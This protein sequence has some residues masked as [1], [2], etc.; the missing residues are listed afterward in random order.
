MRS[1]IAV[2][3]DPVSHH[4]LKDELFNPS[5]PNNI[6]G[7]HDAYFLL[8]ETFEAAGI[9]SH[10]ADSLMHQ[11][12]LASQNVYFSFGILDNYKRLASRQ[13][14]VLS[15]LFTFEAPTVQPS[16]YRHLADASRHF[17]RIFSYTTPDALAR[18]GCAGLS[19]RP[20]NIPYPFSHVLD[21]LWA[22]E[23]RRFLTMLN[24]NRLSR[25]TWQELYTERLR[26]LEFFSRY[27]EIDLYGLGW[28]H[29][30]YRVGETWIPATATRVHRLLRDRVP[31]LPTHPYQKVVARVHR[32]VAESKFRTQSE[33]TFTI[34]YENMELKGWI[35]ENIFDCFLV[36]TVPIYLG[37]PDIADHVPEECFIDK[38]RFE[39]YVEL[40][41]F[42]RNLSGESIRSYREN[43]RD[44]ICSERFRP[45]SKEAF[46]ELLVRAVEEDLGV[47][48]A[49]HPG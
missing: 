32:G 45:F 36:G 18:F 23:D 21:D 22:R 16:L 31:F 19:F 12:N 3:V 17:R 40:R 2:F 44:F 20:F 6:E 24:W 25:T 41:S 37:A 14:V 28:N 4:F 27:D 39:S 5:N 30:P 35:N 10:T 9:R 42:L 7:A 47:R 34:C 13:D 8:R 33:Y 29:P 49:A 43:A 26:A 1:D 38:R 15:G 48:V 11:E 46:V